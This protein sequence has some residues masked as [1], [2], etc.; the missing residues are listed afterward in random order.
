MTPAY[1][2]TILAQVYGGGAYDTSTYQEVTAAS[3]SSGLTNTGVITTGIVT[4]AALILLTAL[5]VRIWRRP[6]KQAV[7]V[8]VEATEPE[9][10]TTAD[11]PG[12]MSNR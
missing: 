6:S 5:V 11:D 1:H 12:E 2:Y 8:P 4:V 9:P 10:L 3:G 7:T